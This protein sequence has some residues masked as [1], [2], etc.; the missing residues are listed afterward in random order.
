MFERKKPCTT[1]PFRIGGEALRFLG[2]ERAEEIVDSITNGDGTFTCHDDL[3]KPK[4]E[5]QHC[6]GAAI[7]L[8]SH[9]NPNQ[10]MR[11][12]ERLG[13]YDRN[14]LTCHEEV[15]DDFDDFIEA[16]AKI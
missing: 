7:I 14:A 11:I 4:S 13:A 6:A 15:F 5:R 10:M 8:E 3:P 1:C 16:Q 12:F 9:D 2:R